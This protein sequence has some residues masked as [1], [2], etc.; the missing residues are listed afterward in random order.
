MG[1]A[2]TGNAPP[3]HGARG[4]QA[5]SVPPAGFG[6]ESGRKRTSRAERK[7]VLM[8][9]RNETDR[10]RQARRGRCG[11]SSRRNPD[12]RQ[13]RRGAGV[14]LIGGRRWRLGIGRIGGLA[15]GEEGAHAFELL[16][17]VTLC[18]EAVVADAM[19]AVGQ[20]MQ[21]EAADELVRGE[22]HDSAPAAS[23]VILV[24]EGDVVLG[25]GF[26]PGIGDRCAMG[27]AGEVGQYAGRA[28]E[29]RL[30]VDDPCDRESSGEENGHE[31]LKPFIAIQRLQLPPGKGQPTIRERR[32]GE[33]EE[34]RIA[35]T[36]EAKQISDRGCAGGKS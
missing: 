32:Q 29:R 35:R 25:D 1:L 3:C 6:G 2:P 34:R 20:H 30:G 12:M 18:E 19:E 14:V 36:R 23:A 24:A 21:Q 7:A 10:P 16:T 26:D 31:V 17:A 11:A 8:T 33:H 5:L 27:V 9:Y 15:G 13:R 4:E 22:A 28:A